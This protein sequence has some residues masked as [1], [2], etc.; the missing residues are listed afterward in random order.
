MRVDWSPHAVSDLKSISE[1]IERDRSLEAADRITRTIYGAIQSLRSMPQLGRLGGVQGTRE[2]VVS[3]LPYFV[4]YQASAER[5][6]GSRYRARRAKMS[7]NGAEA[8]KPPAPSGQDQ[9]LAPYYFDTAG[10]VE[11]SLVFRHFG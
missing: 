3:G 5:V 8:I 2:L 4:V 9:P 10:R 6:L 11:G 7:V 1:Y